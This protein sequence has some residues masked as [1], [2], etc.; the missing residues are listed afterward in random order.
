MSDAVGLVPI[1]ERISACRDATDDR[2]LE[3]AVSGHAD[4][5]VSGDL[6]LL[7]LHPFRGIPIITP[8]A[9]CHTYIHET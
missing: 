3:L 5:I 1:V 7:V 4:T 9:F 2:F 8:R 6:D